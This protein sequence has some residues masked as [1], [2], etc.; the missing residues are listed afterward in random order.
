[1][2]RKKNRK[3]EDIAGKAAIQPHLRNRLRTA[4]LA[5]APDGILG[6][7]RHQALVA[8]T[9]RLPSRGD[10]SL[11][12]WDQSNYVLFLDNRDPFHASIARAQLASTASMALSISFFSLSRA[13]GRFQ[14]SSRSGRVV[15]QIERISS[16]L[17]L[18]RVSITTALY[19]WSS[20]PWRWI[21]EGYSQSS[22]PIHRSTYDRARGRTRFATC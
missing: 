3:N 10:D 7:S 11:Q 1:M 4:H 13:A 5:S 6:R 22:H 20:F 15:R 17:V 9:L 18:R 14:R 8:F 16:R 12:R 2:Q 21:T 19:E